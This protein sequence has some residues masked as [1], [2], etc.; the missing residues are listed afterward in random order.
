MKAQRAEVLPLSLPPRGLNREQSAAYIGI[1]TSLF[2]QMVKDGTMPKAK[3]AHAR[4]LWDR[5]ALDRAFS[6]L[7]GGDETDDADDWSTE[8]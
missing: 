5:M 7:P 8:V 2:D 6:R 4:T 1:S 3:R